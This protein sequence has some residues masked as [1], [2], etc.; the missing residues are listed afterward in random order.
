[1]STHSVTVT[2]PADFDPEDV[3]L[4]D[5]LGGFEDDGFLGVEREGIRV[6][7]FVLCELG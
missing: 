3:G 4:G 1:M 7:G 5:A 6:W 2:V